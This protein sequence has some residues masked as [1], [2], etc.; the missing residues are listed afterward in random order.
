MFSQACV[1]LSRGGGGISDPKS[2]PGGRGCMYITTPL[3]TSSGGYQSERYASY[4]NAF[5]FKL[6]EM[7]SCDA[8]HFVVHP[9]AVPKPYW[10]SCSLNCM[11]IKGI[12]LTV[13]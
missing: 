5:L 2:L 1:I 12:L 3:L 10:F 11:V 9:T 7:L 8:E 4:W 13:D 6:C